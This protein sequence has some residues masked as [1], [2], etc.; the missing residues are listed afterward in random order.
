MRRE[1]ERSRGRSFGCRAIP[2]SGVTSTGRGCRSAGVKITQRNG[3][4]APFRTCTDVLTAR[5]V[6]RTFENRENFAYHRK[7][8]LVLASSS[9]LMHIMYICNAL[10][11]TRNRHGSASAAKGTVE[12]AKF[13]PFLCITLSKGN[14]SHPFFICDS[15]GFGVTN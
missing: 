10:M 1:L 9:T 13:P 14:D 11:S 3:A 5:Q 6:K 7:Y 8:F 12:F 2:E 15:C 4:S